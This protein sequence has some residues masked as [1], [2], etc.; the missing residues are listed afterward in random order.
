V[1]ESALQAPIISVGGFP[2]DEKTEAFLEAEG[3]DLGGLQL[4]LEG[5]CHAGEA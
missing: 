1:F 5:L 2:V 3:A 4:F